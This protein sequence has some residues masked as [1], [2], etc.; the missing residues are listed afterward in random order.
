MTKVLKLLWFVSENWH[1]WTKFRHYG[2]SF[3]NFYIS[4]IHL[5]C[6]EVLMPKPDD[7]QQQSPRNKATTMKFAQKTTFFGPNPPLCI[8]LAN[9]C[10]SAIVFMCTDLTKAKPGDLQQRMLRNSAITV[11]LVPELSFFG[12]KI[13]HYGIFL[14]FFLIVWNFT[15]VR[16]KWDQ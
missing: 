9:F 1:F 12:S 3:K 4:A 7:L 13:R 5:K 8:F 14:E 11:N 15:T 6:T 2:F 16:R 10:Q